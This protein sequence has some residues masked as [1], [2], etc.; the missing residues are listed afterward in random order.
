MLEV[1]YGSGIFL[2]EL[3][4]HTKELY[5]IDIHDKHAEIESILK[6]YGISASLSK[7]EVSHL[8]FPSEYFD[9]VVSV[10]TLEFVDDLPDAVQ[11]I[12]RVLK[13]GGSFLL[14]M[15][16]TSPL[17]DLGL[18]IATGESAERDYQDRR[19]YV[20]PELKKTMALE[21]VKKFPSLIPI[22]TAFSFSK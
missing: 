7:A 11:E 8:P 20:L 17:L 2:P 18:Y 6:V 22:Y 4:D 15:P 16:G 14:V 13:K 1:G 19:R 3:A 10:S 9:T 5:G 12:K 21:A